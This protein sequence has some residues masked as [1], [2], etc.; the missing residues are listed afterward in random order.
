M[1]GLFVG[2]VTD[3]SLSLFCYGVSCCPAHWE[4]QYGEQREEGE[5]LCG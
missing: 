1:V 3:R 4:V 2:E 5:L